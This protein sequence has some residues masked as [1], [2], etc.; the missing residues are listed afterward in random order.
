MLFL[1]ALELIQ[2]LH[3]ELVHQGIVL[4]EIREAL[5]GIDQP[6]V[7]PNLYADVVVYLANQQAQLFLRFYVLPG[8]I[9]CQY[10]L[11]LIPT[12]LKEYMPF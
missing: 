9:R 5:R 6:H 2:M 3:R 4:N 7:S 11:V 12:F 1:V 10:E 8:A